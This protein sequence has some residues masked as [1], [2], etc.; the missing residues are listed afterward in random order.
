MEIPA[1]CFMFCLG[2]VLGSFYNVVIYRLP[3]KMS[4][5]KPGSSCPHCGHRLGAGELIP[6]LSFLW[7]K[8]RCKSCGSRISLRYP[9]IELTAGIGFAVTAYLSSSLPEMLV[10]AVF[11]SLL[12][13]LAVIDL[14]H[15]VLP[16]AL[17]LPGIGLGLLF[18]LL[19]WTS[20]VLISLLG[21]VFGFGLMVAIALIS[22][23]GMGMGDAK[24][25]ALIGSFLGWKAI[26]YVLFVA[27]VVGSVCGILYLY[28]T[29][30]DRK[31]PIPFGPCLALAAMTLFVLR[32]VNW[33]IPR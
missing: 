28:L 26:L 30:Q 21:A 32:W 29:Q 14:E 22:R 5:V 1:V 15:K 31:T 17:T 33:S 7:Q 16:D 23:G 4:L 13:L 25:M 2:L 10:G 6:V 12:L 18:A 8:G 11:F 20:S 3:R 19:G 24:M 27:S 9:I